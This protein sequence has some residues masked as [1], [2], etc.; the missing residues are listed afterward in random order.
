MEVSPLPDFETPSPS[1]D[2]ETHLHISLLV[3]NIIIPIILF[4][5]KHFV[6]KH[7]L[8]KDLIFL[9]SAMTTY[10]LITWFFILVGTDIYC[11]QDCVGYCC[12]PSGAL[13]NTYL[14]VFIM[15]ILPLISFLTTCFVEPYHAYRCGCG[16]SENKK[17]LPIDFIPTGVDTMKDLINRIVAAGPTITAGVVQETHHTLI[18]KTV[19][20]VRKSWWRLTGWEQFKYHT[21]AMTDTPYP[22]F[23]EDQDC[24]FNFKDL[25]EVFSHRK[26]LVIKTTLDIAPANDQTKMKHEDWISATTTQIKA[27][28]CLDEDILTKDFT[29]EMVTDEDLWD[30]HSPKENVPSIQLPSLVTNHAAYEHMVAESDTPVFENMMV[31]ESK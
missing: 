26:P 21:W 24:F 22:Y 9:I 3:V 25:E 4:L 17:D 23:H 15:F 27:N 18:K 31:A 7:V 20:S 5:L 6:F 10:H 11:P 29:E 16:L 30:S 28:A 1:P 12:S 14:N 2:F 8:T 13:E 19:S